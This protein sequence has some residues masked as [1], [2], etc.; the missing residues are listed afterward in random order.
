[1]RGTTTLILHS[2]D[3]ESLEKVD[4]LDS[5]DPESEDDDIYREIDAIES[6]MTK[7]RTYRIPHHH[8][9][10]SSVES[11]FKSSEKNVGHQSNSF[12]PNFDLSTSPPLMKSH[13]QDDD[14]NKIKENHIEDIMT[15]LFHNYKHSSLQS[16]DSIKDKT[17][18][19]TGSGLPLSRVKS[20]RN[21]TS[22]RDGIQDNTHLRHHQ[23]EAT[24]PRGL[25]RFLHN[26]GLID[27]QSNKAD[28][29]RFNVNNLPPQ[30]KEELKHIYVY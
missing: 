30:M 12:P 26:I 15:R 21:E 27:R 13:Y 10:T 11:R 3:P 6:E 8:H 16:S 9:Q 5:L 20:C 7:D 18:I 22:S 23:D 14:A 24:N 19:S 2:L 17:L 1:M 4:D 25:T 28:K 29:N